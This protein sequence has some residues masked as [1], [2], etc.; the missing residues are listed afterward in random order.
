MTEPLGVAVC[1]LSLDPARGRLRH[2]Q[3][4]G[5]AI[6]AGMFAEL[7]LAG[8]IVGARWPEAVGDSDTGQPLL[9]AVHAAVA[10]RRPVGW[11]RWFNHVGADRQ[12]ATQHLVRAGRWQLQG[13]R[14]IDA[15]AGATVLDQQRIVQLLAQ[16][17]PPD[18]LNTAIL[19]LLIGGAG[20]A[21]RPAPRRSR[22]LAKDWLVPHL[23]TSGRGGDAVLG[24]VT[25]SMAAMK[26]ANALP[27]FA[28]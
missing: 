17:E 4:T 20:G 10:D 23:M 15:E 8:R 3:H 26:R 21:G 19:T 5:I 9:D 6:R 24:A 28:R 16:R 13:D 11:R 7:A 14:I 2:P 1:R 22:K 18:D 27:L 25:A 12:A